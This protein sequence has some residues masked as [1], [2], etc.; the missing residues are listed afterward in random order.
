LDHGFSFSKPTK[1]EE[2]F[3]EPRKDRP[4]VLS[5]FVKNPKHIDKLVSAKLIQDNNDK[6]SELIRKS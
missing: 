2:T 5:I 6:K 1:K 4:T 3:K